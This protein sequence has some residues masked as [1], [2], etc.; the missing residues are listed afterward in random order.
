ML[1]C[2]L[3]SA[4]EWGMLAMS[5]RRACLGRL[6]P[7]ALLAWGTVALVIGGS[8]T[9]AAEAES[10]AQ[11]A[12]KIAR[13]RG[14]SLTVFRAEWLRHRVAGANGLER[15]DRE[16]IALLKELFLQLDEHEGVDE[17]V[18]FKQTVLRTPSADRET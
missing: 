3:L 14:H 16:R 15:P 2:P 9:L 5:C 18:E 1:Q 8:A 7:I 12:L 17:I 11:S 10:L 13:P 6:R 4:R